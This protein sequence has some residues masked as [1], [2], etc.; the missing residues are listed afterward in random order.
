MTESPSFLFNEKNLEKA[1][2]LASSMFVTTERAF[3][4]IEAMYQAANRR[5]PLTRKH[6]SIP[7]VEQLANPKRK[8]THTQK[9]YR[10]KTLSVSPNSQNEMRSSVDPHSCLLPPA[11]FGRSARFG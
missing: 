5:Y 6:H 3:V 4:E 1:K 8:R 10:L 9:K 2:D 7:N 11:N